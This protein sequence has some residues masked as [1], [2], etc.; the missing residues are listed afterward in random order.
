MKFPIGTQFTFGSLTFVIGEDGDL[1]MLPSGLAPEHL[2]PAPSSTSGN[3]CSG[4]DPFAGL[5]IRTVKLVRGILI[6]LST[7]RTFTGALSSS[8]ST[9]SPSRDSSDEY[10]KIGASACG[11]FVKD[12]RLI[13]M[14]TLN[15]DRSRNSSSGYPTIKRS[16]MS[17]GQTPRAG[18]IQNLNPDFNAIRVQAIMKT[19]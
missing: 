17:D 15:G 6:V 3:T 13:L 4:L 19:I 7:L 12:S 16:E 18:L 11:K 1:K 9:S 2:V 8:S 10:L 5:Y 14:V